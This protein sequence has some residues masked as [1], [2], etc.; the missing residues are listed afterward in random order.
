MSLLKYSVW[1]ETRGYQDGM[2]RISCH[3][4]AFCVNF[5]IETSD[6]TRR[7]NRVNAVLRIYIPQQISE[8][9]RQEHLLSVSIKND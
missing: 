6:F 3:G 2:V 1:A 4:L 8:N 7:L 9:V 5:W